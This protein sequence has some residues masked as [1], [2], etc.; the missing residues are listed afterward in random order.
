MTALTYMNNADS[1]RIHINR[2]SL[3]QTLPQCPNSMNK[4]KENPENGAIYQQHKH[5]ELGSESFKSHQKTQF[6]D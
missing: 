5:R 3:H 1:N 2:L 4:G 6:K